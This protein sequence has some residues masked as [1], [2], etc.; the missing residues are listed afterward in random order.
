[1]YREHDD[2][3]IIITRASETKV[4]VSATAHLVKQGEPYT[5]TDVLALAA[6]VEALQ[7]ERNRLREELDAA[8]AGE[9]GRE[10]AEALQG[11]RKVIAELR[12]AGVAFFEVYDQGEAPDS[13]LDDAFRKKVDTADRWLVS[14]S[15]AAMARAKVLK[16]GAQ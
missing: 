2:V 16:G 7:Q 15:T 8:R 14:D 5:A 11:A 13:G 4:H 12:E 3:A 6:G 9:I 1:M 10:H